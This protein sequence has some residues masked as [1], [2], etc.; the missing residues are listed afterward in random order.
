MRSANRNEGLGICS[1]NHNTN[2]N[3]FNVD[4]LT[5]NG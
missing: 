1:G 5:P 4:N 3:F 2:N